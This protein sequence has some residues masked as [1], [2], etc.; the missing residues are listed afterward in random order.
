[1]TMNAA[2]A[3][4]PLAPSSLYNTCPPSSLLRFILFRLWRVP[5]R[6]KKKK[7]NLTTAAFKEGERAKV[8][9]RGG[10]SCVRGT[11]VRALCRCVV[12]GHRCRVPAPAAGTRLSARQ[13]R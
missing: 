3:M 8:C 9:W 11:P 12:Q 7:R 13:G 4:A 2:V 5:R 10:A 6:Q 1:M